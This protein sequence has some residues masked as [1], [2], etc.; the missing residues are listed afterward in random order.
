M[1]TLLSATPKKCTASQDNLHIVPVSN[2]LFRSCILCFNV[3]NFF[4]VYLYEK[5]CKIIHI[6]L[7]S[8]I[9]LCFYIH[10][11]RT[12]WWS[13]R[14]HINNFAEQKLLF[15]DHQWDFIMVTLSSM[16]VASLA[17]C[18]CMPWKLMVSLCKV[19]SSG[20]LYTSGIVTENEL[21]S[22]RWFN[23]AFQTCFSRHLV[24]F[25]PPLAPS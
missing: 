11:P 7:Q 3:S 5:F 9:G 6:F 21:E 18:A 15:P 12:S 4:G 19:R 8:G 17:L 20:E 23:A 1:R 25:G 14:I 16:S 2:T 22:R 13:M 10:M 24:R